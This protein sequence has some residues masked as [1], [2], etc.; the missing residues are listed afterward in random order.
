ML[1]HERFDQDHDDWYYK[2]YYTMLCCIFTAPHRYQVYLDIKDTR[3]G[4][5]TRHLHEVLCN[6]LYDFDHETAVRVQQVRSFESAILQLT[7]L[8]NNEYCIHFRVIL[9]VAHPRRTL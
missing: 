8:G 2:M 6:S 5:K 3:G 1:D 7:D 9:R 4:H